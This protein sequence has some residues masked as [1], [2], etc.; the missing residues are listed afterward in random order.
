MVVP[1]VGH[2]LQLPTAEC[3]SRRG[4]VNVILFV[5]VFGCTICSNTNR[6][7]VSLFG[8][9]ANT[10]R[11]FGTAL[12]IVIII[13]AMSLIK[14]IFALASNALYHVSMSNRNASSLLSVDHRSCGRLFQMMGP[15]TEKLGETDKQAAG[16]ISIKTIY[17]DDDQIQNFMRC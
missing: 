1:G 15:L 8:T 5:F 13:T 11:I 17:N 7:F 2:Q 14:V 16:F 10:K 3:S 9:E 6:L 4:R 12:I